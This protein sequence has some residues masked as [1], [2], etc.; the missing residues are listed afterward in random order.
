MSIPAI[1]IGCYKLD[2][3]TTYLIVKQALLLGYRLIDTAA[4]YQNEDAV[5]RAIRDSQIA[6]G[7]IFIV[8][9]VWIRE[10]NKGSE[11]IIESV[12]SSINN[13][14]TYI[15]LL[16]LH[17]PVKNKNKEAWSVLEKILDG[18]NV[19]NI[20]VSNYNINNLNEILTT[21]R[22]TPYANQIELSPFLRREELCNFCIQNNI[23]IIAHSSL[24][25]GN[26][27]E[28]NTCQDLLK[29]YSITLPKLLLVWAHQKGY[30]VIPRT[31]NIKHLEENFDLSIYI[32]KSDLNKIDS[33]ED[34]FSLFPNYL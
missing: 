23:K 28:T 14:G 32:E 6:R 31:S 1:G 18:I 27:L 9:K 3:S 2:S 22:I 24:T 13:L 19:K 29:K 30:I 11:A 7:D 26:K 17:G 16:L 10:I 34:N 5:G 15:D 12:N 33:L 25:R 4:L 21:C 20:G 8:T